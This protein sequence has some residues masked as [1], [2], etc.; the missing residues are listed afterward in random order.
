MLVRPELNSRPP[1]RQPDAQ[2]TEPPVAVRITWLS[3]ILRLDLISNGK[4]T[5]FVFHSH[6]PTKLP[7]HISHLAN[8]ASYLCAP[9]FLH[10][11]LWFCIASSF[12]AVL[13]KAKERGLS[14]FLI[15]C[16]LSL[17][18]DNLPSRNKLD[19]NHAQRVEKLINPRFFR[20]KSRP[21]RW[22]RDFSSV[23]PSSTTL[24]FVNSQLIASFPLGFLSMRILV[25]HV[26]FNLL[27]VHWFDK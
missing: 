2:P 7:F 4:R 6:A 26:N 27:H 12:R 24:L 19:R 10:F 17:P 14:V 13:C 25:W 20:V 18:L 21:Y 3:I 16:V 9:I 8:L 5:D 22:L 11:F 15:L 1:A 23:S